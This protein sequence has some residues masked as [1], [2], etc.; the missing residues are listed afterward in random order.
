M[1]TIPSPPE[2]DVAFLVAPPPPPHVPPGF[3][4]TPLLRHYL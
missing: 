2:P 3:Q 4:F 1:M